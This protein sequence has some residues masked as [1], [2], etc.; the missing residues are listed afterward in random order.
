MMELAP[1]KATHPATSDAGYGTDEWTW[2]QAV[3]TFKR[4]SGTRFPTLCDL[5][6]VFRSLG[7]ERQVEED[8]WS[9]IPAVRGRAGPDGMAESMTMWW[10]VLTGQP[11]DQAVGMA[12]FGKLDRRDRLT[13]QKSWLKAIEAGDDFDAYMRVRTVAGDSRWHLSR[14]RPVLG[15]DGR[16]A[17][18]SVLTVD[19]DSLARMASWE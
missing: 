6:N 8:P 2:M 17:S 7:Y 18:W 13:T 12:P 9:V 3:E 5:F 10:Q 19:V 16:P 15:P 14:G 11:R 1:R 4:N